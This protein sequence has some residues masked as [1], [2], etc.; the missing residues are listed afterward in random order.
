[1]ATGVPRRHARLSDI[2]QLRDRLAGQI[3]LPDL[4]QDLGLRYHEAYNLLRRL[5]LEAEQRPGNHEYHLTHE[6]AEVLRAE[7][8]R[9]QALHRR[10]MKL[11]AAA[12]ALRVA[13]STAALMSRTGQLD[14]DPETDSSGARFITR[15]S[16]QQSWLD[17]QSKTRSRRRAGPAVPLAEV[18]RFTGHSQTA[19][20]D[21][22]RA[23]V[24][25][26]VPGHR[27]RQLTASSLRAWMSTC[28]SDVTC[29]AR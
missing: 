7:H 9:I 19:L 20:M 24:L 13:L 6:A 4:A 11:A 17:R 21:L 22:V 23:G 12:R 8:Q 15:P 25:E 14:V 27:T 1:D 29:I 16:V 3:L 26:E 28:E 10:S 2:W 18:A 5:G